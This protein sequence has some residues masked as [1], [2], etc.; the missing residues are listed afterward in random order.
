[1]NLQRRQFLQFGVTAVAATAAAPFAWA[2]AYPSRPVRIIVPAG[3]GG[4]SDVIARLIAQKL[5]QSLGKSFYVENQPGAANNI[6]IGNAARAAPDGYTILLVG[7][8]FTI[9]PGLFA[10][11]PYDPIKSFSPVTLAAVSPMAVL[12]NPAVPA[13]TLGELI[14]FLK[15]NPGKYNYASAGTGTTAHLFGELLKLSQGLDLVH[16][17]FAGSEPAIQSALAGHTPIAFAALTPAV[18]LVKDGQ[19]R[20]LAVTTPRRSPALSEV[21]SVVDAGLPELEAD[22]PQGM[23]VPAGTPTQIIDLLYREVGNALAQPDVKGK[24]DAIGFDAVANT[25]EDY[26]ARIKTELAKWAKVIR[27]ANIKPE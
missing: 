24:L 6:G 18:S 1:M 10:K 16:V 26:A 21:P 23:F 20:A 17:P 8:N 2:Q 25:P 9:N 19:L 11:I 22:V 7:S 5:S 13:R 27:D 15:A 14:A 12:V 4:P 3:P